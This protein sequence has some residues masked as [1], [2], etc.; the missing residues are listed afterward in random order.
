MSLNKAT[1]PNLNFAKAGLELL[2]V[3]AAMVTHLTPEPAHRSLIRWAS[4]NWLYFSNNSYWSIATHL[5]Y[6]TVF[7]KWNKNNWFALTEMV[8]NISIKHQKFWCTYSY[9]LSRGINIVNWITTIR[10]FSEHLHTIHTWFDVTCVRYELVAQLLSFGIAICGRW[11][12]LRWWRLRYTLLMRPNKVQTA[13]SS[14]ICID[15]LM[16]S[17]FNGISSFVGYLMPKPFS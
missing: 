3:S 15:R 13:I 11:F 5:L 12:D 6:L 7:S 17:W 8:S 16:S 10:K 1:K 2:F 9:F 4:G 14:F